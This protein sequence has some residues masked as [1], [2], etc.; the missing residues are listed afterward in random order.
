[1]DESSAKLSEDIDGRTLSGPKHPHDAHGHFVHVDHTDPSFLPNNQS[2]ITTSQKYP[3]LDALLP[4]G[5]GVDHKVTNDDLLDVHVGNPLRKISALLE[6]IKKQKAFSFTL[7]GSLGLAG[8]VLVIGTFG[9]F[10]GTHAL[11]SKGIQSEVGTLRI[12]TAV[13]TAKRIPVVSILTDMLTILQGKQVQNKDTQRVVLIKQ[14]GSVLHLPINSS[15]SPNLY[16]GKSVIVTG[17]EDKCS[18]TVN[19][20]DSKNIQVY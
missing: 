2:P 5:I 8:I 20:T 4:H 10:G 7:K 19:V 15:F 14:N 13:D 3:V 16:E 18:N 9:F 1:M 12:L 11:C 6:E 17:E